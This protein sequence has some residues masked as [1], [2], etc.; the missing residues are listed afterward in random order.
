[1]TWARAKPRIKQ[2]EGAN[3][4]TPR[5]PALRI[6]DGSARAHVAVPKTDYVRSKYLM[7]AYRTIPCQWEGCGIDDGT[8]CGAHANGAAFG[9]GM[10]IKADDSRCASLCAVRHSALDQGSALSKVERQRGW[11]AAHRRT[12]IRLVHEG[13]WDVRVPVPYIDQAPGGWE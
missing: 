12:V 6:S 5:A 11:W 9:K 13:R 4:S 1:M 2:Y 7:C 10:G 3:P 8:V